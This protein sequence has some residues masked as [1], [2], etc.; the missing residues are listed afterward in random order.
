MPDC[1]VTSWLRRRQIYLK[2]RSHQRAPYSKAS[3]E[4]GSIMERDGDD[5]EM[6]LKPLSASV[7]HW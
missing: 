3:E 1:A 2:G 7:P 4:E 5:Q 6:E